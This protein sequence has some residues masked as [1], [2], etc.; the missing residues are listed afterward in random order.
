MPEINH[1][2]SCPDYINKFIHLNMEQLCK[3]YDEGMEINPELEKGILYFL[4]SQEKNKMDVQFMNDEMMGEIL[5]KD[6]LMQLKSTIEEN[7]KLL[8]V[9]DIDLN[10]IF[11]IQI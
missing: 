3:I 1:V 5:Q 4:C 11:L 8:F 2:N 7:K 10:S 6:S 9:Q